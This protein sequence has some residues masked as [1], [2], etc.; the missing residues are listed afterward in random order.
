MAPQSLLGGHRGAFLGDVREE[1]AGHEGKFWKTR[2]QDVQ[3]GGARG[4]VV[5]G[6]AC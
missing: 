4:E 3:R 6:A 5:A 2:I 1:A